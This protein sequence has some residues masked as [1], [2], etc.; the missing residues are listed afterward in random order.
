M[1]YGSS[2]PEEAHES[3]PRGVRF[4]CSTEEIARRKET[5]ADVECLRPVSTRQRHGP[6]PKPLAERFWRYVE[7]TETCW[8]WTGALDTKGYGRIGVKGRGAQRAH[9][10]AWELLVGPI[11]KGDG[12]HGNCLLHRCD[13]P[14]CSDAEL[15]EVLGMYLKHGWP[16]GE[17]WTPPLDS[18]AES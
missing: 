11:P 2:K 13:E 6:V 16:G 8:L 7:K 15:R 12:Y 10:I 5:S 3:E 4:S 1:G 14:R 17:P 18:G 9:R